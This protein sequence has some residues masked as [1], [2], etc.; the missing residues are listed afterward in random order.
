MIRL[1]TCTRLFCVLASIFCLNIVAQD[2]DTPPVGPP[3]VE[4]IVPAPG[5]TV[6]DLS[7]IEVNFDRKVIGVDAEDLLINGH[8]ALEVSET[9]LG[10]YAFTVPETPDGPVEV[11]WRFGN[12]IADETGTP[13]DSGSWSYTLNSK[14]PPQVLISEFMA[15]NKRTLRDSDGDA[16]D[17]IELFN[18]S[19]NEASLDGWFLSGLPGDLTEWRFPAVSIPAKGFLVVFASGKDKSD[20][21]QELHTNFKLANEGGF[22]AL[23]GPDTNIV[24]AFAPSYP[25]QT[26]DVS[27]GRAQ[28]APGSLGYFS[29]ATPGLANS[30]S[31]AGFAGPVDFS[32]SSGV[33][34]QPFALTLT[35]PSTNAV[36]RY[37][38]N[39]SVPTNSSP[40]Y[41]L[42]IQI[43]NSALVLARSFEDGLLPGPVRSENFAFFAGMQNFTST[44]PIVVIQT[45]GRAPVSATQTTSEFTI[46][47]PRNGVTTFTNPPTMILRGG[48]HLRGSSTLGLPKASFAVEL[49]DEFN[50]S[51]DA[52]LL[53]LPEESDWVLYGPNQFEPV[54]IHNPL[55]HHLSRESGMYSP[56]TRFVEVFYQT[57]SGAAAAITTNNYN[58]IYVLEEKIKIGKNRV[59]IDKLRPQNI[60]PPEVTGGYMLKIDRTGV[61]E[62]G[63][64]GAGTTV[65]YVDPKEKDIKLAARAPQNTYIKN[66]FTAFGKALS[67]TNLRDPIN[68]YKAYIDED[69]W[70]NYHVLEVLSGNVDSLVLSAYFYKPRDGKI[71]WG[72]HWDFDRALGS[73]DGRDSNPRVWSTG[74]F[75]ASAW[76][77]K[78]FTDKDFWQKWVD[79][80]QELRPT[81]FS[82]DH[83]GLV[84]DSMCDELREAQPR[85]TKKWRLALR[86]GNGYQ[87]EVDW[88]KN[89][90]SNR[91]DFI[92]KQLTQPAVPSIRP[93]LIT[94]GTIVELQAQPASTIYYTLDGT[95]PRLPQ[96]ELSP[97]ALTYTGPI[98][99]NQNIK[100]FARARNLL[101]KQSGGP[102]AS[103]PWSGKTVGSYFLNAPKLLVTEIN[104]HPAPPPDGV[105]NAPSD[106]EFIELKN[107]GT[108]PVNLVG[109][110]LSGGAN[111]TFTPANPITTLG[112]GERILLVKN[113][114][115]FR[116]RYPT[117]GTIAGEFTGSLSDQGDHLVFQGPLGEPV[118]DFAYNDSWQRLA[119][120]LGY[121]LTLANEFI[122]PGE[123]GQEQNWKVSSSLGGSPGEADLGGIAIPRI[124]I[125]EALSN[126]K[127][128]GA[129]MVE[130]YNP[131]NFEVNLSG[132]FL[133]DDA[134]DPFR[135]R[136]PDGTYIA[137]K[138]FLV[139]NDAQFHG[140]DSGFGLSATGDA[141]YL[142]AADKLGNLLGYYHGFS[143]GGADPGVSFGVY[144][145]SEGKQH[146]VPQEETSFGLP[147]NYPVVG[148]IVISEIMYAPG[149][150][151][152][153]AEFIE[154]QNI[155]D[156][157]V[158][159][160]DP[161]NPANT[162]RIRGGIE[163]NFS[164]GTIIPPHGSIA[165]TGFNPA[166]QFLGTPFRARY[167]LPAD[168]PVF[169]AWTGHLAN[170]GDEIELQRPID[171]G[172]NIVTDPA[173]TVVDSVHYLPQSPWPDLGGK[174]I[175]SISRSGLSFFGDD[176]ANWMAT[177]PT[178]AEQ[179][180]DGDGLPD[181]WEAQ[182]GFDPHSAVDND[183]GIGDPD[184][185]GFSNYQE[186]LAGSSPKDANSSLE[187]LTSVNTN[188]ELVL[189]F[190]PLIGKA[191]SIYYRDNLT[192]DTWH[193]L[194][195]YNL[196]SNNI[197]IQVKDKFLK[198]SR[199]YKL[200]VP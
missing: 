80:W 112:A 23:V 44:L 62:S 149:V 13:F 137:G 119:D 91:V 176:P 171:S 53:G 89:W 10:N 59:D 135:Y 5:E 133:S 175:F 108:A 134:H 183:S 151:N 50:N 96:G 136:I 195:H 83:L 78:V 129:D 67:T 54:M 122:A 106:Y 142:F 180:S 197:P 127:N 88:I 109:M 84:V 148:P 77:S 56:R 97:T 117:A 199:Y 107:P 14:A 159:L 121:T 61:G 28:G 172:T 185:D 118:F 104:F 76:W 32:T 11:H 63:F 43:T 102:P 51:K 21:S 66:Y 189:T 163:Y 93:G 113:T 7:V 144:T 98:T 168:A 116:T 47:E 49:W 110:T 31:G 128:G 147:N 55:I 3:I 20:P 173:Y 16:S 19:D 92:D 103:T 177:L 2:T 143:F 52:A 15:S 153:N 193:A 73:T 60:R 170:E 196:A 70:I 86:G 33:F 154:L 1:F 71:T 166:N 182:N 192:S 29:K 194:R 100:L 115:A 139:L 99:I 161:V 165:V 174:E 38:T 158:T 26:T 6:V 65:V 17:W 85:E 64:N 141:V 131:M 114:A 18:P 105:T 123:L 24:S 187:L 181:W 41:V 130:L 140:K 8:P 48:V 157:P 46:F 164:P 45:I 69:A 184:G 111:Y 68:G 167:G 124:Q 155:T 36:I 160:Y 75:F 82:N 90:L 150:D 22:L 95:D 94:S 198:T 39:G 126:A 190:A 200:Q 4:Q 9:I 132:W 34:T 74:P 27:Y 101:Q 81:T 72:P 186:F 145:S 179:D 178:P 152:P 138:S 25:A 42:P 58:G 30:T 146:F 37:T 162:W 35:T 125:T 169:G 191:Y 188:H 120:G 79:R 57:K 12:G 87:G 156:L 40:I